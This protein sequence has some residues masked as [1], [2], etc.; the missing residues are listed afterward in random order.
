MQPRL[1]KAPAKKKVEAPKTSVE[2]HKLM[3]TVIHRASETKH[4]LLPGLRDAMVKGQTEAFLRKLGI[5]HLND[6][7]RL[8]P[9]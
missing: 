1:M 9:R 8:F 4:R 7:E 5:I 3:S 2:W 6:I